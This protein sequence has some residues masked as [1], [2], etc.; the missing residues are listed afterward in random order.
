MDVTLVNSLIIYRLL[1][2]KETLSLKNFRLSV[3]DHLVGV[4][5][6]PK[7]GKPNVK[8]PLNNS[9]PK[10]TD[11]VRTAQI[12]HM[13]GVYE[14]R[15]RCAHCNTKNLPK[16]AKFYC[17]ICKIPLCIEID[18]NCFEKYHEAK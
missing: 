5:N 11:A 10:V 3:V 7:R 2:P 13:P 17:K 15:R 18:N 12:P 6:R 9:K 1:F 14:K 16:R 4:P 8:S